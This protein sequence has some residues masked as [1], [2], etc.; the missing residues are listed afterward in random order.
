VSWEVSMNLAAIK[1]ATEPTDR[2]QRVKTLL[3]GLIFLLSTLSI[4]SLICYFF[5]YG[6][7]ARVSSILLLIELVGLVSIAAWIHRSN[8]SAVQTSLIAGIWA[9]ALATLAYDIVRV[10]LAHA[11]IPVFKAISYFG[12]IFLG[13]ESATPLSEIVGWAYHL[14]NGVSF[15][16]MYAVLIPKP[17]PV[18][19]VLW[20]MTLEGVMLLTPYAEV[21]GY[22]RDAK[23]LT[24]TIG[25]H[26]I[27]GLVLWLALRLWDTSRRR[28]KTSQIAFGFL[29]V[30][31][32]LTLMAA[33]FHTRYAKNL[34][35]SPP[36]RVSSNLYVSPNLYT[37]WDVPE[38]DRIVAL[39]V[40][41]RFVEPQASFRFIQP[42]EQIQHG[43]PFD[44]PEAKIR[45]H[46][47]QSATEYLLEQAG[48][49]SDPKLNTLARMTHLNEVTPWMLA[50][51]PEAGQLT[52][53]LRDQTDQDC[54]RAL[55]AECLQKLFAF[56]DKWYD[57]H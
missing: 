45:R 48:L 4:G 17:G 12:T 23:F 29:C 28:L 46:G 27:Y 41:R 21:F 49:T 47:I 34:P 22:R 33:D 2:G 5:G 50:S 7:F 52:Q 44:L 15:G 25:A 53:V 24:L 10:P 51:D 30:P 42:F 13:V 37:T 8:I 43:E 54:G 11:G 26:A 9:G 20:G 6:T 3:K 40:Q 18:T 19:A 1:A 36:S 57:E 32:G 55:S 35:P 38:P 31:V 16:L 56:L 39:W 14:S